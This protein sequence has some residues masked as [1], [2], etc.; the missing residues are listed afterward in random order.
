MKDQDRTG[1]FEENTWEDDE[2]QESKELRRELDHSFPLSGGETEEDLREA[3]G[4]EIR[5]GTD[6][7]DRLNSTFP[8][9]GGETNSQ[10]SRSLED[11]DKP[12][13]NRPSRVSHRLPDKDADDDI[14][15]DDRN[16]KDVPPRSEW[17]GFYKRKALR[18]IRRPV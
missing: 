12:E 10:L 17:R 18:K 5:L 9:S 6:D 3:M 7:D 11:E 2:S 13:Y 4:F 14:T 15:D 16:D 8:L 1:A